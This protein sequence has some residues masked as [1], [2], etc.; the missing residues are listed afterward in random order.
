MITRKNSQRGGQ[1]GSGGEWGPHLPSVSNEVAESRDSWL[2]HLERSLESHFFLSEGHVDDENDLSDQSGDGQDGD[3]QDG[4]ALADLLHE[5]TDATEDGELVEPPSPKKQAKHAV[6]R[7]RKRP[8]AG[9]IAGNNEDLITMVGKTVWEGS[10]A[11]TRQGCW[12]WCPGK[13]HR[14]SGPTGR[15][16][17]LRSAGHAN[18]HQGWQ[19]DEEHHFES[20][21]RTLVSDCAISRKLIVPWYHRV[22][23]WFDS[24]PWDNSLYI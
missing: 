10:E 19:K 3:C 21:V 22:V 2:D 15:R 7:H 24:T 6:C 4:G 12:V 20:E 23:L 18:T 16:P 11:A 1:C 9:G 8:Q 13:L 5:G 17:G 14:F